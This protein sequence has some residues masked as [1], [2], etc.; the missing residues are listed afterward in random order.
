MLIWAKLLHHSFLLV[1]G[2][3]LYLH[4]LQN[5]KNSLF[6]LLFIA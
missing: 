5:D 6:V 1:K 2:D 3:I 4:Q